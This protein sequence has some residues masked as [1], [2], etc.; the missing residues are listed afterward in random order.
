MDVNFKVHNVSTTQVRRAV[1]I[2]DASVDAVIDAVSIEL[3][4]ADD[5]VGSLTLTFFGA[6]AVEA[7]A[8]F[9]VDD[10]VTWSL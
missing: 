6:R 7:R 4:G 8:K 2:D 10:E 1:T 9:T 5:G 3:V